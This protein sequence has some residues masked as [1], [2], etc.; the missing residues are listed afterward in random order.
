MPGST[1][2][3]QTNLFDV[4]IDYDCTQ[5]SSYTY[6]PIASILL[7]TGANNTGNTNIYY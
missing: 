4:K 2:Y 3:L 5:A 1:N 6:T 7:E